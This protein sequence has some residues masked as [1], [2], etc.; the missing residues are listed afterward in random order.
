MLSDADW[1][2][3]EQVIERAVTAA[4]TAEA[5]RVRQEDDAKREQELAIRA[6]LLRDHLDGPF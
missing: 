6:E 2:R 3:L 4:L 1:R 5:E